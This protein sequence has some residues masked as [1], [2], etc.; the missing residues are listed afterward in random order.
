MKGLRKYGLYSIEAEAPQDPVVAITSD[1]TATNTEL[2]HMRLGHVSERGLLELSKQN[3]LCGDRIEQLSF[4]DQCVLGKA[5]RVKFFT[6][7][8]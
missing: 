6:G 2:W 1:S 3:L 5:H 7:Q 8:K 4:C